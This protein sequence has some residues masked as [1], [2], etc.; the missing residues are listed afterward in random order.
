MNPYTWVVKAHLKAY[1]AFEKIFVHHRWCRTF[2]TAYKKK[3]ISS[4][5][6][7]EPTI[8]GNWRGSLPPAV[9]KESLSLLRFPL[10]GR[11]NASQTCCSQGCS[12]RG[13][14]VFFF[15]RIIASVTSLVPL[16]TLL[17]S[18]LSI[19]PQPLSLPLSLSLAMEAAEEGEGG[20]PQGEIQ[21]D[22]SERKREPLEEML[23]RHR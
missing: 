21:G 8:V 14:F 5:S 9:H 20:A 19:L 17:F 7:R 11:S 13:I 2:G 23:S 10:V 22:S 18:P 1:F 16:G 12:L 4:S 3:K 15:F 6:A